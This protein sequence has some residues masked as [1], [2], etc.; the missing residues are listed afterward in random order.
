M[1]MSSGSGLAFCLSNNL[2]YARM[3]TETI[4]TK[5]LGRGKSQDLAPV[6]FGADFKKSVADRLRASVSI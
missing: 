5:G 4:T 1:I 2:A 6:P 3:Q